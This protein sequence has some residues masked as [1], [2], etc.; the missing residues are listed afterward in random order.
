MFFV[1]INCIVQNYQETEYEYKRQYQDTNK[2]LQLELFQ[3]IPVEID[4]CTCYFYTSDNDRKENMYILVSD[5]ALLAFVKINEQLLKF[6]LQTYDGQNDV[7][8]YAHKEMIMTIKIKKK[9]SNG[10]LIGN[11]TLYVED[12]IVQQ[13]FI[14][15]C[16]C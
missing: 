16:E 10:L 3:K 7:F 8:S 2:I 12:R 5:F 6:E 13:K 14:A 9:L 11:I 15:I 4:G 1:R